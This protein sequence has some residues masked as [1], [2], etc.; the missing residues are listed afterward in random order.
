MSHWGG[1]LEADPHADTREAGGGKQKAEIDKKNKKKT[2]KKQQLE[3]TK[4]ESRTK[5]KAAIKQLIQ[6]KQRP[7]QMKI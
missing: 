6:K 3:K 5:N 4:N 1:E 7:K 2:K